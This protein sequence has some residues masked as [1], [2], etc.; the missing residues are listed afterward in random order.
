MPRPAMTDPQRSLIRIA[1]LATVLA[2][3]L[4]PAVAGA[5]QATKAVAKQTPNTTLGETVLTSLGGHTLY[6][7]SAETHGR[8]ICTGGCLATWHPL[9]VPAGVRPTGPTKLGTIRR[10][11]GRTQVVF[12]GRPLY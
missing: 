7:L 9:V 6:S 5:K 11:D 3:L 1:L 8:F 12:E 4:G 2:A 10:P